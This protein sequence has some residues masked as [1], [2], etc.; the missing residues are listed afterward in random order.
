MNTKKQDLKTQD[1]VK[2][3]LHNEVR[4]YVA[5]LLLF[6][7]AIAVIVSAMALI[8]ETN[9]YSDLQPGVSPYRTHQQIKITSYAQGKN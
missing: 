2:Q 4:D 5:A 1:L 7:A 3:I 9:I 8:I 6:T